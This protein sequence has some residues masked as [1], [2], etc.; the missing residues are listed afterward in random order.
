MAGIL[1]SQPVDA[2]GFPAVS[3]A[4][5]PAK[6]ELVL[7]ALVL[8]LL[9]ALVFGPQVAHG[10]FYWDDWQ[11]VANVHFAR[12]PGVI[13]ALDQST[14]RPVFGY[15]PGLTGL[16]V[17]EYKA[18]GQHQH[19][20]LAMAAL[21]GAVTA[22]ALYLLLRTLG[23]AAREALVPAVLLLVFPWCDSTRMWN[24][25]SF[26][27]LAV[28]FYLLGLTLAVRALRSG[29]RVLTAASLG[30]YLVA[31]WTYEV[32]TIAVLA[33]VAVCLLVAPR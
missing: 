4:R 13:G 29:S 5:S 30:L 16:L 21:F 1:P 10:G 3:A 6:R 12:E 26:D 15:R 14:E 24:T 22:S 31:A 28:T 25:A 20:F 23:V 19:L 7:T 9:T 11:N 2:A 27:T 17:L 33:S 32:V 18:L 8:L